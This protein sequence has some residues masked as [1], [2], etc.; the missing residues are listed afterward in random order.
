MKGTALLLCVI[1]LSQ[2]VYAQPRRITVGPVV[3]VDQFLSSP[4]P[5]TSLTVAKN[6]AVTYN[7]GLSYGI[8][9]TFAHNKFL[10]DARLLTTNRS[11][12]VTSELQ[13]SPGSS[14]PLLPVR[15]SVKARYYSL[16]LTVSYRI[17]TQNHI[18]IFAG[19]GIVPEWI[20][21]AFSRTSYDILGSGRATRLDPEN[22]A[23]AFA[24]GGSLQVIGRY[25]LSPRFLA[26]IQPAFHFFSKVQTPFATTDNSSFSVGLSVGYRLR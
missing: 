22:P 6:T 5:V 14:S 1:C 9:G 20:S 19:A 7:P 23:K 2:M 11:Y 21:G 3:G 15:V 8:E 16:P 18:Q 17:T 4:K 26:Q 12:D 24:I 25:E 13:L 10:I